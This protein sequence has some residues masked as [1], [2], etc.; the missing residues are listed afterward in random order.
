MVRPCQLHQF[1]IDL[2]D[3]LPSLI[4][5]D[6]VGAAKPAVIINSE[7]LTNRLSLK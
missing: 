7:I 6:D 5:D 2:V 4:G 3:K 1:I